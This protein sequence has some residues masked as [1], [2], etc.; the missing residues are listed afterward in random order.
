MKQ[1][2]LCL[3]LFVITMATTKNADPQPEQVEDV[4]GRY[5]RAAL[6]EPEQEQSNGEPE[7][8]SPAVTIGQ[9]LTMV[10]VLALASV[11]L[12]WW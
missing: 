10:G 6:N 12:A 9:S 5:K 1:V 8:H 11:K 3:L 4:M 2:T 7:K